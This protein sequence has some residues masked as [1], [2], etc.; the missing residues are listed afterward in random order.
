[1][2]KNPHR[3]AWTV[4]IV[5]FML[6]LALAIALPFGMRTL[7]VNSTRGQNATIRLAAGSVYITRPSVGVPEALFGTMENL[8]PGTRLGTENASRAT[9]SFAPP[10]NH[11][12][13]GTV[14]LY[15]DT[16]A[17]LLE[18][19]T[20]RFQFS[21]QPHRIS[22]S[23][24]R[25]RLRASVALGVKR[26]VAM[27]VHTPQA[28]ITFERPGSYSVEVRENQSLVAVRTGIATVS[29]QGQSTL[30]TREERT[31]VSTGSVP[32]GVLRGERNLIDNGGFSAPVTD[33]WTTFHNRQNADESAGTIDVKV[34]QGRAAIHFNRR[35]MNW[36]E[37]GIRQELG[38]D[39]SDF[40]ELRLHLAT[41]LAFQNLRN[42]GHLGSECPMIVRVEYQDTAGNGHEW[43]QGFFYLGRTDGSTPTR[44]V[45]CAPPTGNH[46]HIPLG[47]WYLY[48]SPNLMDL[49]AMAGSPP[50]IINSISFYASGHNFESYLTDVE[51]QAL[52]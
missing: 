44:C 51:L 5:A 12:T 3:V 45:T 21:K 50:A 36:A 15:G 8:S 34:Q 14:E 41:W 24:T 38:L 40:Q 11:I 52:E 1:M 17:M 22:L 26:P 18:L 46:L 2:N 29:A 32:A 13:L 25:G 30:L 16:E 42:C 49:F 6:F 43:L 27:I 33:G 47:R 31:A 9:L 39:V 48:D 37:V 7:L 23:L 10:D 19:N 20:P 28:K 4:L 35:G